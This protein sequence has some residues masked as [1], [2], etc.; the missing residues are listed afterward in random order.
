MPFRVMIIEFLSPVCLSNFRF[1]KGP[2]I[3]RCA[4]VFHASKTES[5]NTERLSKLDLKISI[6]IP[7]FGYQTIDN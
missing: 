3:F 7:A 4:E 6:L 1:Y 5:L 2:V